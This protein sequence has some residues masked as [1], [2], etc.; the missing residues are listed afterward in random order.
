MFNIS[1]KWRIFWFYISFGLLPL[2]VVSYLSVDAY[3]R[4]VESITKKHVTELVQR[5]ANQTNTLCTFIQKDLDR[6]ANLPYVQLSFQ[7]FHSKQRL[8]LIQE[9]LEL[10]RNKSNVFSRITLY[11]NDGLPLVSTP[12]PEQNQA[13]ILAVKDIIGD[14]N[15]RVFHYEDPLAQ[16]PRQIIIVCRVFSFRDE[17]HPVGYLLGHVALRYF[18]SYLDQLNIDDAIEKI[19]TAGDK[20]QIVIQKA[21]IPAPVSGTEKSREYVAA[22]PSMNWHIILR[23]PERV[24]FEGVHR[25][26]ATSVSF[27]LLVVLLAVAASLVFSRRITRP[28]TKVIKGTREF[29]AGNLDYR[30][31]LQYGYEGKKLAEAFNTMAD[32]LQKRQQELIQ[33]NK[34]AALGLLS[35]GIAHEVKN[36]LA[37]IKT[38][39][40]VVEELLA[41]AT[42]VPQ[43]MP[44]DAQAADASVFIPATDFKNI[45]AILQDIVAEVDRLNKIVAD[46]LNFGRPKPSNRVES[47]LSEIIARALNLLQKQL[48]NKRVTVINEV[49]NGKANIDPDQIMQVFVNLILNAIAAVE[50]D[51]GM[52]RIASKTQA[53]GETCIHI[54]DNGHGIPEAKIKQ[55]FDPFF[56]LSS[57]GTGL[58]L[59]VVYALLKQNDVRVDLRSRLKQGTVVTLIFGPPVDH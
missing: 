32:Q 28:L 27:I 55:I 44:F 41:C 11:S 12:S 53:I 57:E 25:L 46:L 18:V 38:S 35:A 8:D 1:L 14:P 54:A 15:S 37:G 5:I 47:D 4:S 45:A 2:A 23:I 59:A 36:P 48:S 33:Y 24:L 56:T 6:L 10:F 51:T 13:Q 58:G 42:D 19:I 30:I 40:Q 34:L 26:T 43:I 49:K 52:I 9:K 31:R 20:N 3:T 21:G 16:P 39:A 17:T 50:P 7:E 22:V 29:A